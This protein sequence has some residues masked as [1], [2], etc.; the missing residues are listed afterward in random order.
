MRKLILF[1]VAMALAACANSAPPA[2]EPSTLAQRIMQLDRTTA[3]RL[4]SQTPIPFDTHHP[5]GMVRING[6]IFFTSV[7]IVRPTQRYPQPV[8][9][10]DRDAGEGLGHLFRMSES[11][12]LK[13]DIP[14]G[15]DDIYHPGGLDFDGRW[16]WVPVAEYRPD[17][18]SIIYRVDPVTLTVAEAFRV[19]D[20]IGAVAV[21]REARALIGV[22]WG[23]ARIY[24]WP[25]QPDGSVAPVDLAAPPAGKAR[26][27]FIAWQD[28]HGIPSHMM[29]CT[30]LSNYSRPGSNASLSLGGADL[31]DLTNLRPLWQTPIQLWSPSGRSMLQ[32]PAWFEATPTGLRA[33]FMPDDDSS[34]LFT[35]DADL[36]AN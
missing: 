21:D 2:P 10:L 32:N 19:P 33:W 11:G 16:L 35:Y 34:T 14:L 28:C 36:P 4:V 9:G 1:L 25:L 23:G 17:S 29:L 15:E 22:S 5:Q 13:S 3:W 26:A 8:N 31:M 27:H 24:R 6:D 12:A 20:H 30:G 7:E 18:H